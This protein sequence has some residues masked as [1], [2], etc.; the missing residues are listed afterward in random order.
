M[1]HLL[2]VPL[3]QGV[4][5]SFLE[6]L[7]QS[8]W[9]V[10]VTLD[11]VHAKQILQKGDVSGVMMEFSDIDHDPDR[12]KLLRFVHEFCPNT[13]VIMLHAGADAM[14]AATQSLVGNVNR[15]GEEGA[16][17]PHVALDLY[18]LT[19]AQKRISELVAQAYP[20][21]EIARRLK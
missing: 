8:G 7:R 9:R 19:P 16:A 21:R 2:V 20:N 15:V 14:G 4:P 13:R 10:T 18:D 3:K 17:E 11:T 5:Q 6:S 1:D 12:F